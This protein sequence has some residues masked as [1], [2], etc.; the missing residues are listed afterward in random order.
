MKKLMRVIEFLAIQ[1]ERI[2]CWIVIVA[3]VIL[4]LMLAF[5]EKAKGAP[6]LPPSR[7]ERQMQLL[8]ERDI[9]AWACMQDKESKP[10]RELW[11]AEQ[12]WGDE[13]WKK[14][15]VPEINRLAFL[16]RCRY[17]KAEL[18]TVPEANAMPNSPW[19][20]SIDRGLLAATLF[21]LLQTM[22]EDQTFDNDNN[23]TNLNP[24]NW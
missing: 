24:R 16:F 23:Q 10:W 2:M 15:I 19:T 4:M 13:Y 18:V 7:E 1:Q 6:R 5:C 14:N 22:R 17:P 3:G 11:K 12:S 21:H 20:F 9:V 8:K